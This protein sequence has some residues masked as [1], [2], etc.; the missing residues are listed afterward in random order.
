MPGTFYGSLST[1]TKY[2]LSQA[3]IISVLQVFPF[4]EL[5][6]YVAVD[7]SGNGNSAYL[8]NNFDADSGEPVRDAVNKA[9]V[10]SSN[11]YITLAQQNLVQIYPV[12]T[13]FYQST[14]SISYIA[15]ETS[16]LTSHNIF[17]RYSGDLLTQRV[18]IRHVVVAAQY[19]L[20]I[21]IQGSCYTHA[22]NLNLN[23]WNQIVRE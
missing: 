16:P 7:Y 14:F 5:S 22:A 17:K 3:T 13:G 10:F 23:A 2:Q 8:G 20:Q 6:G 21:C 12:Q 19:Q 18:L 15:Y 11:K 1:A 9:Y 4:N